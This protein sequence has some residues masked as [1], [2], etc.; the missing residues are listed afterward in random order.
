[1]R[2]HS[3]EALLCKAHR[4][5][6]RGLLE[7][8]I[9]EFFF[10]CLWGSILEYWDYFEMKS[11]KTLWAWNICSIFVGNWN[12]A[13][14]LTTFV[15]RYVMYKHHNYIRAKNKIWKFKIWFLLF[16]EDVVWI[17]GQFLVVYVSKRPI[18]HLSLSRSWHLSLCM[19]AK[20]LGEA[21]KRFCFRQASRNKTTRMDQLRV[22]KNAH[23]D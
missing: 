17:I 20:P 14:R 21:L 3:V 7:A 9:N 11:R 5:I 4:Y 10:N 8:W 6:C 22:S 16:A 1:M 13:I 12:H 15:R 19:K 23:P 2:C 18:F